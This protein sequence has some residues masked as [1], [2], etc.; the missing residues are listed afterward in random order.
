MAKNLKAAMVRL[1]KTACG[2]SHQTK[3]ARVNT[4]KAF[5]DHLQQAGYG[6]L[7]D[8]AQIRTTHIASYA[9]SQA[10][11]V[12]TRTMAN[13]L[14]H[15]RAVVAATGKGAMLKENALSNKALGASGGSRTG[16]KT[17]MTDTAYTHFHAAVSA[18]SAAA[19][20]VMEL[21]RALGL[22][23]NEAVRGANTGMLQQWQKQ[24]QQGYARITAGTKGGRPR[25]TLVAAH[26]RALTAVTAALAAA[27][28]N[29][30]HVISAAT[31]KQ[32]YDH[33]R[34]TYAAAGMEGKQSSHSLR[35]AWAQEQLAAYKAQGISERQARQELSQDLGHGDGRGRY[36][37]MVYCRKNG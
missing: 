27:T 23:L 12:A 18:R 33:V 29:G 11:R 10:G 28:V 19:G 22:R 17:A 21:Q 3:E 26:G 2:G 6:N 34:N 25:E 5:A 4:V 15:I 37:A 8:P 36:V 30:G 7:R 13:K 35:Y 31:G 9:A 14:S 32:A 16:T 24:L 1:A 20:H